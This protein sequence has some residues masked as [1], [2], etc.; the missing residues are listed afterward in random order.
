VSDYETMT[1]QEI[2]ALSVGATTD[3]WLDA[4]SDPDFLIRMCRGA[5]ERVGDPTFVW[6]A[7]DFCIKHKKPYPDWVTDYLGDVAQR[8]MSDDARAAKDLRAVLPGIMGFPAK[9][10]GPGRP[11]DPSGGKDDAAL[12]AGRFAIEIVDRGLEPTEALREAVKLLPPEVADRDEKTLWRWLMKAVDLKCRPST[13]AEWRAA[14]RSRYGVFTTSVLLDI[15]KKIRGDSGSDK[16]SR[17][18]G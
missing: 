15:V 14:L 12:L 4:I 18:S 7:I 8:M 16:V 3:K 10:P 13:N 17:D 11:L 1:L 2:C 6:L 5:W 9:Q